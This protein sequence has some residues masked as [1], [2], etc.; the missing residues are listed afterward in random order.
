MALCRTS[1]E[2]KKESYDCKINEPFKG[3]KCY[4]SEKDYLLS[5]I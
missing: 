1:Q 5:A 4:V 2:G 3:N